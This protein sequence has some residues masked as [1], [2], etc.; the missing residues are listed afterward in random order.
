LAHPAKVV[1]SLRADDSGIQHRLGVSQS[2]ADAALGS[3]RAA[4]PSLRL[5]TGDLPLAPHQ[6]QR[7]LWQLGPRVG[8][9]RTDELVAITSSLLMTFT[10][11]GKNESVALTWTLRPAPRP[12]L[13]ESEDSD[14]ARAL[15]AKLALPG[16]MAVGE[17]L[18]SA[19]PARRRQLTQRTAAVL[20][21]LSTPHGRLLSD[22]PLYGQLA[23]LLLRRGRFMSVR[24]LAAVTGWPIGGPDLP[25]LRL[26][27]ARRLVPSGEL[28][29]SGRVLGVSDYAGTSRTVALAPTAATKGLYVLGP[30]G[31]GKTSL[32]K[33]LVA[34]DLEQ[35]R[36]LV[37]V[38]T[39]GDLIHDLTDLI[40]DY[41]LRDVI[42]LDPLDPDYAVGFNPF[43]GGGDSALIAD[44]LGELFA[45]LWASS[46]GPR[47]AQLT[48]MGLLTL[49][50]RPG[51]TLLDL[52]RLFLDAAFRERVLRD[53]DDPVGLGPDWHWFDG[54]SERERL[55]V[56]APLL[57]KVRAFT[58]RPNIRAIVG[59]SKPRLD[60]SRVI[61]E[62]RVVL[63]NLSKGLL[64][65]ETAQLLGCLI[66]IATWQAFTRRA[67]LPPPA[68]HPFGLY[69]DEV[70]DFAAAPVPW[71]EL[72][73][74]GRKYGLM[75]TA[76][77]QNLSQ[78]PKDVREVVLANARSKAVFA[79][80]SADARKLEKLFAPALSASDLQALDPYSIAALVALDNGGTS[81][82]V[83][84]LT[85]PPPRE[86]GSRA[87]VV[88]SSRERYARL[89]TEVE[90]ALRSNASKGRPSAS[91]TGHRQ[92]RRKP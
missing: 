23:Y 18:V 72:L 42:L 30:T 50:R 59:Q 91:P 92:R 79:L 1:L 2:T 81:H 60:L 31:T 8:A 87:A 12:A 13:P 24:E 71:D 78:L 7:W 3:L 44:Q 74:Q 27:A 69:V 89:R 64:G 76:A 36:G 70:Q 83:T 49:A 62:Q 65:A 47:T 28:P 21:S 68:R 16:F 53:L 45:R 6:A 58:A 32:L 9:L 85:P 40:P 63:V 90:A 5:A 61:A 46:W 38:E 20:R 34:S 51:S 39:N 73:A 55:T 67:A 84:L 56:I 77:H 48:H 17:L 52:P 57:N 10:G 66:L 29:E 41:R 37:V 26:G 22:A 75:L 80:S 54:L 82:P 11:L 14:S 4:I 15:R 25:G 35:G 86:Q 33:N 43:A 88:A 19:A